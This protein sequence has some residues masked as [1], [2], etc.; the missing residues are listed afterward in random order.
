LPP[1]CPPPHRRGGWGAALAGW[2]AAWLAVGLGVHLLLAMLELLLAAAIPLA[3]AMVAPAVELIQ[4]S[5][6]V[7]PLTP[8]DRASPILSVQGG[9]LSSPAWLPEMGL[10]FID[11]GRQFMRVGESAREMSSGGSIA[12]QAAFGGGALATCGGAS[13][14]L[15]CVFADGKRPIGPLPL[16]GASTVSSVAFMTELS[17]ARLVVG[18]DRGGGAMDV[19]RLSPEE[20]PLTLLSGV[21]LASGACLSADERTLHLCGGESVRR[22]TVNIDVDR[23]TAP[24][25]LPQLDLQGSRTLALAAD[26]ENNLY[27]CTEDGLMVVGENGEARLRLP[28][29]VPATG[30]CFGGPSLRE[31]IVTAGDTLWS[32]KTSTQGVKPVSAEFIQRLDKMAAIGEFRHA[33]W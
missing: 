21:E 33:G 31:L 17:D 1:L 32:L 26:V 12:T 24:E 28:T 20:E 14:S 23:C 4:F 18:I 10:A 8:G 2:R 15:R 19:L 11:R 27:V 9:V 5:P 22:S 7:P 13:R 29:P 30:V 6:Q 25:L 3:S 16:A